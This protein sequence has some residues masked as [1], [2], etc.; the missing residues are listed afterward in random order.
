MVERLQRNKVMPWERT[1]WE[2]C[3]FT[4]KE[5]NET[6]RPRRSGISGLLKKGLAV[7]QY[8]LGVL[9]GHTEGFPRDYAQALKW[10]ELAAAQNETSALNNLGEMYRREEGVAKDPEKAIECYRKAIE[11]ARPLP[12]TNLGEMYLNGEGVRRL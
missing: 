10:Y 8:N 9:Y 2:P 7:A 3:I 4:G 11:L 6:M 5:W 12:M 1:T